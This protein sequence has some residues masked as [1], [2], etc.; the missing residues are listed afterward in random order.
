MTTKATIL[1]V[2]DDQHLAESMADWLREMSYGVVVAMTIAEARSRLTKQPFD[3]VLTDLRLGTEDGFDLIAHVRKTAPATTILVM[4]GYATPDTAVEAI[5]AGAFDLLTKPL[6]DEELSLALERALDQRN[7]AIENDR[8][9][10]QLDRRS[11]MENVLSHDYRMLKI[12]D[13]VDSIAD[14]RASVLITGENGT[15]K[16][17]IARAIHNRSS[18]RSG[19]FVEVA[20]GALPDTLL[21]SE[22]FGHVAGAYTGANTSRAGKFQLAD[23]GTIFLDEI[24]TATQAMQVKLLRVLQELQF[25]QLGG[26][27]THTVDTRVILATNEN[28]AAAVD[29]GTFRQDLYYRVNVVN[30][31]L[32]SLRERIG[33]LPLLVDHFLREASETCN[34]EIER[35]DDE[36]MATMEQYPWPGNIRQ[37]ENVVERAVLL[38]RGSVLTLEDLPPELTGRNV[39][40]F[41]S[42]SS[43]GNSDGGSSAPVR[44]GDVSGK[45]LR[46]ALEG[47]ERQIILQSLKAHHWNRAA[48]ADALEINRTT[49]YKKMKRL[50]LDDPRLQF[51]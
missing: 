7:V 9:R 36:A 15:G 46:D 34:R 43:Q 39:D 12:F 31:V 48:T 22:L 1:L 14:A 17:M 6:I 45:S 23:G 16:S 21:E 38:G 47:P 20:C 28:L 50:G 33:D 3:L 18:R 8:L 51:A 35:F 32:P 40:N 27:E 25:E 42:I 2:D 11:G 5:R 24:G 4:T 19:P 10:Q 41:Q 49:L 44:V 30:I 37:L 26:T 29:A 13:V